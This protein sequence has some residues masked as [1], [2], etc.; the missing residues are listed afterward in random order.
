MTGDNVGIIH[1]QPEDAI[2]AY[3]GIRNADLSRFF[4]MLVVETRLK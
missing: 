2:N 4:E 3:D 1:R